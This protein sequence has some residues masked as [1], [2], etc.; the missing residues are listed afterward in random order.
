LVELA[1]NFVA[2]RIS[3][4]CC[5]IAFN[6]FSGKEVGVDFRSVITDTDGYVVM[7]RTNRRR[8]RRRQRISN[9]KSEIVGPAILGHETSFSPA[10]GLSLKTG[11]QAS[12]RTLIWINGQYY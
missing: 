12:R 11:S 9:D 4:P 2:Q 10:R 3:L 7:K 1:D 5:A 6:D 8:A